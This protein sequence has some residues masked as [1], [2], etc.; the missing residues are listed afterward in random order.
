[1]CR[2]AKLQKKFAFLLIFGLVFTCTLFQDTF[3]NLFLPDK[4]NCYQN[5]FLIK[6][7][8]FKQC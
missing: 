5:A 4:L 8:R 6:L 2:S 7:L 1:M 3:I